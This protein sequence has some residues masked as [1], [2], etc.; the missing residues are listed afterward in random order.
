M[1]GKSQVSP[2]SNGSHQLRE[3]SIILITGAGCWGVVRQ[4]RGKSE[5]VLGPP[6]GW[7]WEKLAWCGAG[8]EWRAASGTCW[9]AGWCPWAPYGLREVTDVTTIS[10]RWWW[11]W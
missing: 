8:S 1:T 6:D 7:P 9:L 2:A 10:R 5:R 4:T 3:N 11:W